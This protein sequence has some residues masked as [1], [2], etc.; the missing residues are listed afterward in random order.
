MAFALGA[1]HALSPG[2]GKTIVAAYLA[3]SRSSASHALLLGAVV[4]LTHTGTVFL[5]GFATLF[6]SRLAMPEKI[7]PLLGTVS[8]LAIVWV[9]AS[10][11]LYRLRASRERRRHRHHIAP[12]GETLSGS[13]MGRAGTRGRV[14]FGSGST[15]ESGSAS[16]GWVW[17][18]TLPVAFV[19]DWHSPGGD[20]VSG[21][22]GQKQC[23]QARE[24]G[25][26]L[27]PGGVSGAGVALL[28]K[29]LFGPHPAR[30]RASSACR[31]RAALSSVKP[32][33]SLDACIHLP[34]APVLPASPHP[35]CAPR[36]AEDVPV[37]APSRIPATPPASP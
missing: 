13:S 25:I 37:R 14:S 26:S 8:G 12:E 24:C 29:L 9:G 20:R 32:E 10:W 33:P 18:L 35:E 31:I 23:Y 36:R 11:F 15:A 1:L 21:G 4:T 22:S 28:C 6:L 17:V 7:Y 27:S 30:V 3:G 5:L 16:A 2:H 19:W 34:L